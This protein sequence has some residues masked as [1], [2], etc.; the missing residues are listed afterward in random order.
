M[1][2]GAL[3]RGHAELMSV[4]RA[5]VGPDGEV[6]VTIFVNPLQFGSVA[7][8]ATYPE[9]WEAD[10]AV[11]QAQ[12]VDYVF[13]PAVTTM[14]PPEVPEILVDP[15]PLGQVAEGEVRPGHFRGVLTVVLKLINMVR[16]DY[17]VFGE[18]DY[19]Q[20]V[21]IQAMTAALNLP[22]VIVAA[23]IVRDHDG[24]ALSSRNVRLSPEARA[25]ALALPRSIAV[26]QRAAVAGQTAD[27]VC[28]SAN[29]ELA[30]VGITP[31]Y[32]SVY[33]PQ[34]NPNPVAGPARILVAAYVGGVHLLDNGAVSFG[35]GL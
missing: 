5:A 25:A 26:A 24:L 19:Q 17:A 9:T 32:V 23:P 29:A 13:A 2:M 1:T 6:V 3:H 14:Y 20:L 12:G 16:P 11:C 31:D 18:K 4:A 30:A 34:F 27:A 8:L 7:D 35:G 28:R 22:V 33:D 21:L 15:G 10:L